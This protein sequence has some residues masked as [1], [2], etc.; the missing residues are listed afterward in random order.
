MQFNS[1]VNRQTPKVFLLLCTIMASLPAHSRVCDV[2]ADGDID[3]KDVRLISRAS[4]TDVPPGDPR[5]AD[6]DG[7]ATAVDVRQCMK[8][9]AQPRCGVKRS[10]LPPAV[11]SAPEMGVVEQ[12]MYSYDV[13]ARDSINEGQLVFGLDRAPAG[14]AIDSNSG[15]INWT[16][17]NSQAGANPVQVRVSDGKGGLATQ[18]WVIHVANDNESPMIISFPPM[19]AS[20]GESWVYHVEAADPDSGDVLNFSLDMAPEGMSINHATGIISWVPDDTETGIRGVQIR[21][22]DG[23]GGI[24]TQ[25]FITDVAW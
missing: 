23:R 21:V 24:A 19:R 14:M 13:Q 16:P 25:S 22:A 17:A 6:G 8:M 12:E 4:N 9:C 7:T 11:I 10:N 1:F 15:L 3:R 5:D 18:S 20:E 2:D